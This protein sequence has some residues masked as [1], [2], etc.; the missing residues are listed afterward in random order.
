MTKS[1]GLPDVVGEI[2][3]LLDPLESAD[4]QKVVRSAMTLLG[5]DASTSG[6]AADNRGFTGGD[7]GSEFGIKATRWM[8]QNEI[9]ASVIDEIFHKEG[10]KVEIIVGEVPGQA[11]KGKT[12]NCYLLSGVRALLASDE[13][14]FSDQ[15]AVSLCKHM[16]CYDQANHAK[17]RSDFGN[18]VAGT[19]ASGF[20][21]PAPGLRAA[22]ALIKTM[23]S[24]G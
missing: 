16:G 14:K 13:P 3:K 5:E 7:E 8:S 22:A 18:I 10:D 23:T 4:R 19:K 6:T 2:Y 11:K 15:E 1:P 12:Q 24:G 9:D 20:A 17:T 21:L